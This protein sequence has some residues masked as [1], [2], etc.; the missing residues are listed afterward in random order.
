METKSKAHKIAIVGMSCR[1]PGATTLHGFWELLKDGRSTIQEVPQNRWNVEDYYHPEKGMTGKMNTKVGGFLDTIDTFDASFFNIPDREAAFID[2]Q[3][4]LLLETAWEALEDAGYD[5]ASVEGSKTSVFVGV[6]NV[7][8]ARLYDKQQYDMDVYT[9]TG[10]TY[11]LAANRISYFFDFKGPSMVVD[12]ACSSSL[13][14]VDLACDSLRLGTSDRALVGGVNLM[15]TPDISLASAQAGLLSEKGRC[16]TFDADSDGYVRGEAVGMMVLKRYEDAVK[17]GDTILAVVA[18]S[19]TNQNGL[20][21]GLIAPSGPAQEKVMRLALEDAAITPQQVSYIEAHGTATPMGDAIEFNAIKNVYG[22]GRTDDTPCTI[23]TVKTNFGHTESASGIIGMIKVVLGMQHK[24]IPKHVHLNTLHPFIKVGTLPLRFPKTHQVWEVP[25]GTKR[26]AGVSAF[27]FGGSNA[28]VILEEAVPP[29]EQPITTNKDQ[30]TILTLS[31]RTESALKELITAYLKQLDASQETVADIG[32]TANR[33]RKHFDAR[34]AVT[35]TTTE[36]LRTA[37]QHSLQDK[38]M[39]PKLKP[40]YVFMCT[41]QGAQYAGMGKQL[42]QQ[43]AVFRACIDTC[44]AILMPLLGTSIRQMICTDQDPQHLIDQTQYTQPALFVFEYALYQLWKSW[45]IEPSIVLGHSVGEYVAACIAGVFSLE[46]GLFLIAKRAALMQGVTTAGK[47]V[48]VMSTPDQLTSHI[49]AYKDEVSIA[50]YNSPTQ[51]IISGGAAAIIAL[52]KTFTTLGIGHKELVVSHGF[53]SPQMQ[54]IRDAFEAICHEVTFTKPKLKML[55]NSTGTIV[56][57]QFTEPSY[58]ADHMVNPVHFVSSIQ[59]LEN[60]GTFMYLEIGP[61]A[62]LTA[63]TNRC[64]SS[65]SESVVVPS[66]SGNT[67]A[68]TQLL[69][70]LGILYKHH[71][72]IDWKGFYKHKTVQRRS[73][74]PLYPFQ[75]KRYWIDDVA[76]KSEGVQVKNKKNGSEKHTD[77]PLYSML[78]N[79][80]PANRVPTLIEYI[81]EVI[82]TMV[83]EHSGERTVD[84]GFSDMGLDSLRIVALKNTVQEALGVPFSTTVLFN[85]PTIPSLSAYIIETLGFGNEEMA[86]VEEVAIVEDEAELLR[87]VQSLSTAETQEALVR[88]INQMMYE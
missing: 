8:Y 34:I 52:M 62:I 3:Q 71:A 46:D 38:M 57:K 60:L 41:G 16:A 39:R 74:V 44:D 67:N 54:P 86:E 85:Y 56:S 81:S 61:K 9:G 55:S 6:S 24:A 28:H 1:V 12:T 10:I 72:T 7:D 50:G 18:G 5:T 20:R 37:L 21:N 48:A 14:A 87:N 82:T 75:R 2:P 65:T 84:L 53:H 49:K 27:G 35:A 83:P 36:A 17:A 51:T 73:T 19:A 11:S 23:S 26:Y 40:R 78:Q 29:N 70:S 33:Y 30:A 22:T 13:V 68:H 47:M 15:L 32:Y 45:G 64:L 31:A 25:Q 58:W 42:Y 4:R 43:E 88:Q 66:L 79:T 63:M 76:T 69:H 80:L 59:Y 77:A